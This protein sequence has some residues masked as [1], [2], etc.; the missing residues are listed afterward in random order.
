MHYGIKYNSDKPFFYLYCYILLIYFYS[1][2]VYQ[3][4]IYSLGPCDNSSVGAPKNK[5]TFQK[6]EKKQKKKGIKLLFI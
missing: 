1:S 5:K 3:G 6:Q 2:Y 4:Q